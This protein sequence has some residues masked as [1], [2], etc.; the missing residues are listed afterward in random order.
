MKC[1]L[2]QNFYAAQ[3][4]PNGMPENE[5]TRIEKQATLLKASSNYFQIDK[6][7][8]TAA[9]NLRKVENGILWDTAF[10]GDS[11]VVRYEVIVNGEKSGELNHKPQT[12]KSMPFAFDAA[13]KEGDKVVV[14]SVDENGD[15]AEAL[16]G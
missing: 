2:T 16:L 3:I 15:R 10:A 4:A 5:R 7:G 1:Q 12:L 11:P 14:V 6:V 13:L 8:L 9:G